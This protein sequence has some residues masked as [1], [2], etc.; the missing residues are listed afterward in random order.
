MK[1]KVL[2]DVPSAACDKTSLYSERMTHKLV[3]LEKMRPIPA[4]KSVATTTGGG[5]GNEVDAAVVVLAGKQCSCR[6]S[7]WTTHV[8]PFLN[9]NHHHCLLAFYLC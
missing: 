6:G 9:H 4:S 5:E 1:D 7:A 8:L 2:I 3:P